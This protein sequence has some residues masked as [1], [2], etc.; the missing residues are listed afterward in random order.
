MKEK[1]G[2]TLFLMFVRYILLLII[3][4]FLLD[5]FYKILLP[6]TI[7]PASF[8]LGLFYSVQISNITLTINS[9]PIELVEA[10][11]A[12]SAYFLLLLLNF[13]VP[14][15]SKKRALS[16][17]FS[18]SLFLVMNIIRISIFSSLYISNFRY[19]DLTHLL[20]WYVLS[21]IIV[22]LVWIVTIKTFKIT[23][24]PFY[25]DLKFIYKNIKIKE[26]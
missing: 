14:M 15:K 3:A 26:K 23:G 13:S 8:L 22:F 7:Y 25:T 6:L 4:V 19:F 12:G 18:F 2:R 20:A 16:L 17:L 24:I 1:E 5:Y 11:I 10:C 21:G 9:I